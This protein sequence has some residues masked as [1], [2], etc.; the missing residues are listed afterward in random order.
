[1]RLI[2]IFILG[3]FL[4]ASKAGA[5]DH[6]D[7]FLSP[8][9]D[10]IP[11][12]PPGWANPLTGPS[13]DCTGETSVYGADVPVA[14]TCLWYVNGILQTDTTSTLI[15][16]WTQ[17]GLKTISL[18]FSCSGALSDPETIS[19]IVYDTPGEPGPISGDTLVCEYTYHNYS[20]IAGPYDS[21]QWTI[22]GVVMQGYSPTITY[23]FGEEGNYHFEVIIFNPCG[24]SAPQALDV[25]AQGSAPAPPSPIQGPAES[26]EGMTDT[27]ITT[28]GP[29]ESCSWWI[30]GVLQS[31]VSTTL[32]VT[33]TEWGEHLIEVRAVSGCGTGNPAVKYVMVMY[34][35]VV[36][37]GN[38]TTILQG[39]AL[40][41]DAGNPGSDYLWSTGET[42]RTILVS[43][44]GAYSVNVSNFCGSGDDTIDV[45]VITGIKENKDDPGCFSLAVDHK[46]LKL[47]DLP[48][49]TCEIQVYTI[50]GKI[51]YCGP[52]SGEIAVGNPGIYFI[53]V[54]TAD[55]ICYKKALVP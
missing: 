41:L 23:S 51:C 20:V 50:S 37:L 15:M 53:R 32:M 26:C 27:Y 48:R 34:Q 24:T 6:C 25:R 43:V 4:V 44:T 10:S 38:D 42:T 31:T 3:C 52:P 35:P 9:P 16:T 46:K 36:F 28:V 47:S 8:P 14:C 11:P 21:C 45:S 22:N 40:L 17:S 33:W 19:T 1:M 54:I 5:L 7:S 18:V 2:I 39:Q 13:S 29:G 49:E 30:D 12:P 55:G